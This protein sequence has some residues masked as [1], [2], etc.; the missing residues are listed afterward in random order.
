MLGQRSA[1]N[2]SAKNKIFVYVILKFVTKTQQSK[3]NLVYMS[4]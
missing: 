1:A 4:L 3:I 2:E